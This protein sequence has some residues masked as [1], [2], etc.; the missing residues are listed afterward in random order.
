MPTAEELIS[1]ESIRELAKI[2]Q[3]SRPLTGKWAAV[4]A[5]TSALPKLGL[6]DRAR[7]VATAILDDLP[8]GYRPL[9]AAIRTTLQD[10]ALSGWMVWPVTEA[11]ALAAANSANTSDFDDGLALLAE[12][13]PR[14]TGEF[15]IRTFLNANLDRT[16]RTV[17]SWTGHS[18]PSVRRLA[19]EGTRPKLPW[20]KQVPALNNQPDKTVPVL[21]QLYR[22]ESDFVRRSVA[23][24]LNDISRL[25][26]GLATSTATRWAS[27]G[28]KHTP[29]L[30]RHSMRTLIKRGNPAA[31]ALVGFT[32]EREAFTVTG[33]AID[34]D[35]V[36]L[37]QDL[38]FSASITNVSPSPAT[39]AIDY[40]I[41]HVKANG[42]HAPHV[43]KLT[44]KT[45]A[46]GA[47]L[48]LT[49]R[50]PFRLITTRTYYSGEH[51]V[52]L[53]IN[54]HRFGTAAFTLQVPERL[55]GRR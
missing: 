6:S 30:M 18:D 34:V 5:S 49:R 19:S 55:G 23:N 48:D 51:D 36:E 46:P 43:F 35:H 16:L 39:V 31:L 45:L 28:D 22:D 44:K 54:G 3:A 37:G 50:H 29:G 17:L 20:A 7:T 8:G 10:P 11:V 15:A 38:V 2:L 47:T 25:D 27:D 24:H 26:P 41:N 52:Q 32:G 40:V 33:P 1:V 13:T 14:L 4:R 9:A 42:R 53:Q 12:L 21:D